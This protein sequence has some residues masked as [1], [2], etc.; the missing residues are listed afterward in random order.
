[1]IGIGRSEQAILLVLQ[2]FKGRESTTADICAALSGKV[3][4]ISLGTIYVA[5]DRVIKRKFVTRCRGEPLL[6]RGGRAGFHCNAG[7]AALIEACSGLGS[8]T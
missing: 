1:M 8:A 7:C 2:S 6:E 4:L 5:I 3:K